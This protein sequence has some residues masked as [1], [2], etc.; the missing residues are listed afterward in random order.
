[1]AETLERLVMPFDLSVKGMMPAEHSGHDCVR[2]GTKL[3]S[4]LM[5]RAMKYLRS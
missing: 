2:T 3:G 5:N 1:M 4:T